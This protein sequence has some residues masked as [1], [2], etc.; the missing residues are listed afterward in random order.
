MSS[1]R[2]SYWL[3]L[4]RRKKPNY[5]R[6]THTYVHWLA[7]VHSGSFAPAFTLSLGDSER[8]RKPP[9]PIASVVSSYYKK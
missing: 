3:K 6:L 8:S 9:M 1:G 2:S 7:E 5:D 4:K